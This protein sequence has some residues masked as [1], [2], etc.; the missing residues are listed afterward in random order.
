MYHDVG[1]QFQAQV[2]HLQGRAFYQ[3]GEVATVRREL[4]ADPIVPGAIILSDEYFNYPNW[5]QHEF[6]AFQEFVTDRAVR[7]RYIGFSR[8]QV[9]VH[10]EA[11]G[12]RS[13]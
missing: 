5:E 6:R 8:Q 11:I 7:Y 4:L 3:L 2:C 12:Y 10:V 13:A 1:N 9:A